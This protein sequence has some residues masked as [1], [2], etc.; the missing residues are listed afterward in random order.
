MGTDRRAALW[1]TDA[2][3]IRHK[4]EKYEAEH[5]DNATCFVDLPIMIDGKEFHLEEVVDGRQRPH[6][7][8]RR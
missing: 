2:Q 4:L 7:R 1:N 5:P 3:E 6:S 8:R